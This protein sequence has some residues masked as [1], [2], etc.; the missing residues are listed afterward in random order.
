MIRHYLFPVVGIILGFSACRSSETNEKQ[1]LMV[2]TE[3]VKNYENELQVTYPGRAKAAADVDLAFR[4]AGPIIR[5]PVQVGSF[6]RKGEVIAE[7]D[8]RDYELQYKATEAEYKQIKS[9]AE[10]VIELYNRKSVPENDYD[11]A[12]YGLQQITSKYNAHKNALKDTRLV[13]PFDGYIQKKYFDTDETVA[14]GMPVISMIDTRYFEVEI[15]VPSSDYVRRHLFNRFTAV[16]DVFPDRVFPLELID[17]TKKANLNQLYQMR[18]RLT[19]DPAIPLAAGMSVNVTID[20][21][22]GGDNLTVVPLSAIFQDKEKSSVWVYRPADKKVTQRQVKIRQILKEG[23][24]VLD[25]GLQSGE[26][27]VT[28][29]VHKLKEG[30][31]VERLKPVADTNIGGLL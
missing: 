3:T 29:G 13:A 28:A 23:R 5:I 22:A 1:V 4:V 12:V 27:V 30:M 31:E 6:V 19:P 14:A 9:E 21:E 2:K 10:R 7:I 25:E 8:P 16:A 11:K 18:L 17:V 20:Y 26:I 24:V 15:D